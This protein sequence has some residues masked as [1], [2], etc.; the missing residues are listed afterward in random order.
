MKTL[1]LLLAIICSSA[2]GYY[3]GVQNQKGVHQHQEDAVEL[4]HASELYTSEEEIV[5]VKSSG[6][7]KKKSSLEERRKKFEAT[8][9]KYMNAAPH[10]LVKKLYLARLNNTYDLAFGGIYE[11]GDDDSEQRK[12]RDLAIFE[13]TLP[14]IKQS[15]YYM[16]QGTIR[17]ENKDI[18]YEILLGFSDW[19]ANEK[20]M[21]KIP[22][23]PQDLIYS[24]I[25]FIDVEEPGAEGGMLL[26]L[27]TLGMNSIHNDG[28]RSFVGLENY[29]MSTVS[30]FKNIA[31][32]LVET[33][34]IE[35]TFGAIRLFNVNTGQWIE[36]TEQVQWRAISKKE[37]KDAKRALKLY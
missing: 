7:D 18:P 36:A 20:M 10:L 30:A 8:L 13:R 24:T 32:F 37:Y 26:N 21:E 25:L 19:S 15:F 22:A 5:E 12:E 6:A 11:R 14:V 34:T 3:F 33:P 2:L 23:K 35:E 9:K 28:H 1:L 16:G 4:E 17:F 29:K 27:S 31:Y